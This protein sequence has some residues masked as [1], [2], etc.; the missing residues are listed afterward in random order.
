MLGG[1]PVATHLNFR[2]RTP[3]SKVKITKRIAD[4]A[5]PRQSRYILFDAEIAGF[6]LRVYPS[7]KK[8]W[9]FEYRP[10]E[11]G[12][13]VQKKRITIGS[14]SDFT[15]EQARKVAEKLRA[16]AKMGE[17][18]QGEKAQERAAMTVSALAD[19]F[20]QNHVS[21]RTERTQE[22][23][24]D[25]LQRIVL[26]KLG[27]LKAKDVSRADLSRLHLAWKHTPSQANRMLAIVG[28][29][30]GYGGKHGVV[31]EGMNPARGVEKYK[32][33]GRERYLSI[34]ELERLGA[35]IREAETNGIEWDID[36]A[37]KSKHLPKGERRTV[38]GEHAAAAI[39]LLLL[40][41]CR[42]RE[43]LHLKW[44]NVDLE[45]GMLFLPTSK[46]GKKAVV[47]NAPAMSVLANLTRVGGYVIAS[48][49]AG[50]ADEKPRADLKR[51]WAV[52]SRR[53][54]LEGVRLHDLRHNFAAFGAGGGM[55]LPIIGKLLGHTQAATTQRYAHLDADPLRRASNAIGHSI[56][57][58][59]GEAGSKGDVVKINKQSSS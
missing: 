40:T 26:P 22:H 59:L 55:G 43:I 1:D 18:P 17:D 54:G 6:G 41:G 30:Y 45:R 5:E 20:L 11:G 14:T 28:S 31:H 53:A 21:K 29:M 10:G 37:K 56:A 12:R 32:E 46:T 23:Y 4:S 34:D 7:G 27:R 33:Q 3:V 44:D 16:R 35:A 38:I 25:V 36:P 51:P 50:T 52:V 19:E 57:A 9:V 58:A 42:L 39:R 49:T 15:P 13:G 8:S 24:Q 2:D 47:L 48:N